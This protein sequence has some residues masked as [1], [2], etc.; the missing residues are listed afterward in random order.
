MSPT[1]SYKSIKNKHDVNRGKENNAME[2]IN[3]KN[4]KMKSSTNN[5]KKSY[6]NAKICYI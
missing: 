3:I 2:I 5:Q 6:L 1:S 4:Q